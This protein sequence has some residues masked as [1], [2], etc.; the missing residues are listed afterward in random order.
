LLSANTGVD[1]AKIRIVPEG[2]DTTFWDPSKHKPINITKL[3]L[4]QATGPVGGAAVRL[5][6]TRLGGSVDATEKVTKPYSE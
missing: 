1:P 5:S 3:N 4:Q 6:G 2:L